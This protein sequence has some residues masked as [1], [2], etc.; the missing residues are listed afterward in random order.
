MNTSVN[1]HS[2]IIICPFRTIIIDFSRDSIKSESIYNIGPIKKYQFQR[3][4]DFN[5]IT[6][7]LETVAKN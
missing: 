4:Q 5:E 2:L 1:W 6:G 3:F 7:E